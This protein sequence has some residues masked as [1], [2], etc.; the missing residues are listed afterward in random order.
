VIWFTLLR[1]IGFSA[2]CPSGAS[3]GLAVEEAPPMPAKKTPRMPPS[4]PSG[5]SI[6]SINGKRSS[7]LANAVREPRNCKYS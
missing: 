5:V 1:V 2:A 7:A 3:E 4:T 6:A